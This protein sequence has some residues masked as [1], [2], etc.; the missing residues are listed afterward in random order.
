MFYLKHLGEESDYTLHYQFA[1]GHNITYDPWKTGTREFSM[2]SD[3][4]PNL[5]YQ[6]QVGRGSKGY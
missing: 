1:E 6:K 3:P 4:F 2:S 5:R